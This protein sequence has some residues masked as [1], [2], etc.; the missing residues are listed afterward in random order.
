MNLELPLKVKARGKASSS[1]TEEDVS[2][3]L[4]ELRAAAPSPA[5]SEEIAFLER[6]QAKRR[7]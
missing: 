5:I 7:G 6:L 3:R 1:Y 2:R 4:A